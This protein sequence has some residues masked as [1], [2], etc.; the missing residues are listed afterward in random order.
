MRYDRPELG[1]RLAADYVLGLMLPRARQRFDRA[2][3]DNATLAATV[4]AWSE[5]LTPLDAVTTDET[6]PAHIW[7][8]IERRIVSGPRQATR[9]HV[10]G[11]RFSWRAFAMA[12]FAVCAML[13]VY[14]ALDPTPLP[15]FVETLGDKIGLSG[16]AHPAAH[17]PAASGLSAIDIGT[18]ERERPRWIRDAL[19][20]TDDAMRVTA[21][22]PPSR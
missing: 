9:P 5:L 21:E 15:K 11:L 6:P 22:Q 7:R 2:M 8:A 17:H 16:A 20:L 19:L 4:A 14:V 18:S 1:E 3:A 13:V 10:A 12:A